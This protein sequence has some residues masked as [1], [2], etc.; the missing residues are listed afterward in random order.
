MN[1]MGTLD[2]T[3]HLLQSYHIG[4]S[5]PYNPSLTIEIYHVVHPRPMTDIIGHDVQRHQV[6]LLGKKHTGGPKGRQYEYEYDVFL[7]FSLRS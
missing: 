4:R 1:I 6:V 3:V 2:A 5:I 7:H